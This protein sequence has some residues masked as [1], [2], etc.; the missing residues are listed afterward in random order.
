MSVI[1][2]RRKICF[3]S[4][5]KWQA[6]EITI[7]QNLSLIQKNTLTAFPFIIFMVTWTMSLMSDRYLQSS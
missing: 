5:F 6:A 3:T 7:S 2:E 4:S 1:F